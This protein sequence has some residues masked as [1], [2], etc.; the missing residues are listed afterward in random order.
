MLQHDRTYTIPVE[1]SAATARGFPQRIK[2]E[3]KRD[4]LYTTV[5]KLQLE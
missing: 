1:L 2:S 5:G 4:N 3:A